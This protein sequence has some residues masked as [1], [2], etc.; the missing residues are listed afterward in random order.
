MA[1]N[2][3]RPGTDYVPESRPNDNQFKIYTRNLKRPVPDQIYDIN[4][5]YTIDRLNDLDIRIGNAQIQ[6]LPGIDDALNVGKLLTLSQLNTISWVNVT[7]DNILDESILGLKL[8]P[9]TITQRELADGG[10]PTS[11]IAQQA[12]TTGLLADECVTTDQLGEGAVTTDKIGA[13]AVTSDEIADGAI[14]TAE[15][16]NGAVT[17]A[18]L[19]A[20]VMDFMNALVPIGTIIELPITIAVP[21]IYKEANGQL[22]SRIT[23]ASLF[24]AYGTTYGAGDGAT[25]FALP[26]KRG[27]SSVGIG[28]DNSTAGRITVATAPSIVLG[29]AFGYETHTLTTPQIPAH[30]HGLAWSFN[31]LD[32][33]LDVNF[34]SI[35]N[36]D[37][38]V[39]TAS[40][41][42]GLPHNN[43]QPSIF[44][45]YYVR[46]L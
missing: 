39:E 38:G 35:N 24:A 5:G 40:T 18:K 16:A 46:A 4:F 23:Y 8:V 14:R 28:S 45:K 43:V 15:L 6:A 3:H 1:E 30:T 21:S 37:N 7:S 27:R 33:K 12:I 25:T 26:D 9:Q 41:G 42:G 19:N 31:N 29:G 17:L 2:Y 20:D 32:G 11:K 36:V 10:I 44:T 22:L 34:T 13:S